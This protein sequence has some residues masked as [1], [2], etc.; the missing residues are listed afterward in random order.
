MER[1][2]RFAAA[3]SNLLAKTKTLDHALVPLVVSSSQTLEQASP[4]TYHL[5]QS[6][7]GRVIFLVSLQV[8][9]QFQDPRGQKGHLHL[10]RT[11]ISIMSAVF[12]DQVLLQLW[13]HL[14][15]FTACRFTSHY[16]VQLQHHGPEQASRGLSSVSRRAGRIHSSSWDGRIPSQTNLGKPRAR[17]YGRL[18]EIKWRCILSSWLPGAVRWPASGGPSEMVCGYSRPRPCSRPMLHAACPDSR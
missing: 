4:P 16:R 18:S 1:R 10:L 2:A 6:P 13:R 11:R 9:A 12:R 3:V 15:L 7:A 17:D 8:V 14:G 5:E